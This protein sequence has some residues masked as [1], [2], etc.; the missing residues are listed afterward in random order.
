MRTKKRILYLILLMCTMF[1]TSQENNKLYNTIKFKHFSTSE[2]LSQSSVIS[3]LQDDDGFLWFGTR[4]GL[5]KYDGNAF[6]SYTYNS[7]NPKSLSH[8]RIISLAKDFSGNVWVGTGSGLNKYNAEEDNFIRLKTGAENNSFYDKSIRDIKVQD[9][10]YLWLATNK[11]LDRLNIKTNKITSYVD[12]FSNTNSISSNKIFSLLIDT[13]NNLW[14]CGSEKID[15]YNLETNT[16]SHYNYPF[17]LSPNKTKNN[18]TKLLQ[19]KNGDIWLG[20]DKGL[21]IFNK[22]SNSFQDFVLDKALHKPVINEEV[23]DILED[24]KGNL[25]V[26]SYVGLFYID[27][28]NKSVQKYEHSELY[29]NSLSQNSVYKIIEDSRGDLWI[30][31]WAGG[32]NYLDKSANKF[33]NLKVGPDK[34]NLNYKVVSSIVETNDGNL[35]IG[36]EGGGINFYNRNQRQFNY[37][38]NNS[39]NPNSLSANNVK[40]MLNDEGNLWIGTHDGGLNFLSVKG[41]KYENQKIDEILKN[42]A[43]VNNRITCLAKDNQNKIWIGTNNEGLNFFDKTLG[44]YEKIEDYEGILGDFIYVILKSKYNNVLYI[45]S[46][47]GFSVIDLITNEITRIDLEESPDSFFVKNE[48]ISVYEESSVSLWLGTE[49]KGLYNYNLDT[50]KSYR[51]GTKQGLFN[52][53]VYGILPDDSNNLWLSTNSGLFRFNIELKEFKNFDKSDG[54][55]GNEFNYGAYLKT[56]KGE[57]IFGGTDGL[58]ILNPNDIS[59]DR[60]VPPVKITSLNFWNNPNTNITDNTGE[61]TLQYKQNDF[62][63]DYVALNYSQPEKNEYAYMLEGFDNGWKYVGNN[64]TAAYTN[65]NPGNYIFRVKASN[66]DGIWNE[67]AATVKLKILPP[68]WR[69]WWAYVLYFLLSVAIILIIRRYSLIRINDK[70]QLKQE[71]LAKEKIEKE[72][73]FKLQLFTNISHDFRTPLTLIVGP[74]K[75]ILNTQN[76]EAPLHNQLS[77]MYRN[78]SIL[79]QLINQLL[80]FRKSEAGKLKLNASKSNI[81]PFL[82][83]LKL[84]FEELAK[85]RRI[86]YKF[87]SKE[88]EINV[89]FSKIEMKKVILNVLSNAFKFT[90]PNGKITI[91]VST[92]KKETES[93]D[94][95]FLKILIKDNGKGIP[96]ENIEFVFDRY[97]QLG[98]KNELRS[99]TGVG[100]ALAKDIVDLHSGTIKVES[101]ENKGT[102]FM[103]LLPMGKE[104]LKPEEIAEESFYDEDELLGSYEPTHVRIG[105][106]KEEEEVKDVVLDESLPSILIVEDNIEVRKFIENIFSKDFNVFEARNGKKGLEIANSK[107]IDLIVSD[108]MMPIMDGV[109]MCKILKS[110]VITSHIPV[111]LLTARTSSKIQKIGYETGADAYVTKPFDAEL[112]KLQVENL[113]KSRENLVIKFKKDIILEP[114][115]LPTQS[116]DEVFLKDAMDIIEENMSN[117][118]FNV[119]FFTSKMHMSQSVLYRKIKVLTG[120]SISEFIRTVRLKRAGQLLTQTEM[121]VSDVA[122]DI[123]FND[124]K[125]FRRCFKQIFEMSPSEYRKSKKSI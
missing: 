56:R 14:I 31:T 115:E 73:R 25:W 26:G 45:G 57:L 9:S 108:I 118:E 84:A 22:T 104:H 10:V 18:T 65:L 97:F 23:R 53:V 58:T 122:Y 16:F 124:L 62:S 44:V 60:F 8:N 99:G 103:I 2:G 34:K 1:V 46:N 55:Q 4:Y 107:P 7:N 111:I 94:L 27:I 52:E 6:K 69:T 61:V 24:T 43:L 91:N 38:I 86:T 17:N 49:G 112:L 93:K 74:L 106:I 64:K 79:L 59:E 77:G 66:S 36:T 121:A 105:W 116:I 88:K 120:Q 21:A 90:P 37:L 89:W 119:N 96:A 98:Q 32:I 72:N 29:I 20:Y 33:T 80:D 13:K 40:T 41:N 50:N 85:E 70:N 117:P 102:V 67:N 12:N 63:L 15:V 114:K 51:Y 30:G 110:D 19:D 28:K 47:K 101:V 68:L 81:V 78:A 125:Y 100:L 76:I 42:S 48:V 95:E 35:W 75:R 109:E 3:I 5:N 39:K 83:N 92:F 82:E 54:I 113:L 87:E 11:G 123:G 71:R